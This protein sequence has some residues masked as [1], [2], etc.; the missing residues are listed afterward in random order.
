MPAG[1]RDKMNHFMKKLNLVHYAPTLGG[2]RT[3]MSHPATSSHSELS[4]DERLALGIT[5][6]M[7]RISV[8]IEDINDLIN[9]FNQALDAYK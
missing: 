8:G 4:E 9:D 6:G 3:T 5:D 1:Q 7:M 2:L